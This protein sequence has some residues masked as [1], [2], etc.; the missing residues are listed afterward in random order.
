[1]AVRR[2][3]VAAESAN[4]VQAAGPQGSRPAEHLAFHLFSA[5]S[6]SRAEHGAILGATLLRRK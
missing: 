2:C 6:R 1:M 3:L 4:S 5:S